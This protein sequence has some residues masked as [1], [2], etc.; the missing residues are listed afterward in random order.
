M[1]PL[2]NKSMAS[3]CVR[4]VGYVS[5]TT[6]SIPLRRHS[7]ALVRPQNPEPM[8]TTRSP[9]A[10]EFVASG[11]TLIRGMVGGFSAIFWWETIYQVSELLDVTLDSFVRIPKVRIL[12]LKIMDS[13][14]W[15]CPR[16]TKSSDKHPKQTVQL[17]FPINLPISLSRH[18]FR[19]EV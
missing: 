17:V 11:A 9:M 18:Y 3:P 4:D 15:Q 6:T 19:L 16:H 1:P 2:A 13:G 5:T 12:Q 7:M 14:K 8:M 10:P